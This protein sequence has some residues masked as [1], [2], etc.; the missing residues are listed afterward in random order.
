MSRVLVLAMRTLG[1]E[2]RSGELGVLML[3]LS[4]WLKRWAHAH[5]QERAVED[6]IVIRQD[7]PPQG[8]LPRSG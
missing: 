3:A 6:P 8:E 5:P 1:R 7:A 4:P 2:W